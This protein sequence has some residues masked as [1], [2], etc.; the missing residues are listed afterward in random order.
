MVLNNL[1]F[2]FA[3]A[4][5]CVLFNKYFLTILI[6]Y[7]LNLLIDNQFKKPQAFHELPTPISGGIGIFLSFLIVCLC[8]ILFQNN[9]SY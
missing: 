1:I 6:K 4:V 9:K 2:F 5:F 8:L 3:L 7:K